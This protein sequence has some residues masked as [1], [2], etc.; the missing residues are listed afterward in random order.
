MAQGRLGFPCAVRAR[1]N[2]AAALAA[3]AGAVRAPLHAARGARC[4]AQRLASSAGVAAKA[5]AADEERLALRLR[6]GEDW[7]R[8][9]GDAAQGV[10]T[11]H[12]RLVQRGKL[13]ASPAQASAAAALAQ[14]PGALE[15]AR[16]RQQRWDAEQARMTQQAEAAAARVR[17]ERQR[18]AEWCGEGWLKG[19]P[20]TPSAPAV[21]GPICWLSMGPPPPLQP[22]G[23]YIHGSV[24]S[25]K[26]TL[27]D[28]FCLFDLQD[29]RVRR[30]HWH[31]FSLWLHG[32]LHRLSGARADVPQKHVLARVADL[33]AEDTDLICLDEF[34]VTNVADAAILAELLRLL[35]VRHVAL[36]CTTNRPPQDL[37]KD[38]LHRERFVPALVEHLQS[39]FLLVAVNT[40]DY[41]EEMSLADS[42]EA[43]SADRGAGGGERPQVFFVGGDPEAALRCALADDGGAAP[44]LAP[45]AVK[46]SW[47]RSLPVP[48][49]L[50]GMARFHFDDLCRRPLS[51]EDF[52]HLAL[53]F[54]TIYVHDVPGLA[55][56]EHNEAR[57]FTNLVDALYEHSV[58][59]LC[60]SSVPLQD[61]LSRVEVLRDAGSTEGHDAE[62]LGVYETMYDDSP[63]FQIQIKELGSREKWKELQDRRHAE[64]QLAE[65]RRM[66]RLAAPAAAEGDTGSG[67]SAAPAGADLSAPDQGVAGVMVAA[68]GSL[69]ESGFAA[70][71]AASRLQEMQTGPYLEAARRRREAMQAGA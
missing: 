30:Q 29:W 57:R 24:G 55:L 9:L 69:Q 4:W 44:E 7:R 45:G 1:G 12:E 38:G 20:S 13:Q 11:A 50:G 22:A 48:G 64:E 14:L 67:W 54:H 23:C 43:E 32:T 41:R 60:H 61:V 37:Y 53:Q 66:G 21:I 19:S 5:E 35:A 63:N 47:G 49:Q 42:R 40:V 10:T 59:L 62:K 25:G 33:V 34:A 17:G 15:A 26:S 51:A 31:E 46:V 28:L 52:M 3:T 18:A 65:A 58:R 39:T 8:T 68:V 71:R 27:M 70:R 16:E 2:M 36:V 56:E 6:L